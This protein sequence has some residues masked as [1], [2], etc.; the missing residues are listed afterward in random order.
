M[1]MYIFFIRLLNRG[2]SKSKTVDKTQDVKST[3]NNE[4]C[5]SSSTIEDKVSNKEIP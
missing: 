2:N 4:S 1:Y 5:H 3:E